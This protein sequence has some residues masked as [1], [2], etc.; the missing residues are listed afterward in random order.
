LALR[1]L[2]SHAPVVDQFP[3]FDDNLRQA[4]R[5]ETELFFDSILRED[6]SVLELLTADY[7]FVNDRLAE[8]YGIPGVQGS[9]FRRIEL[10]EEFDVRRGLL[11]K[12]S[13][14]T[15]SSQPGRTAPV[16][17]GSWILSTL[18]GIPP[19]DPP[20]DVPDLAAAA[21]DA[22]GNTR[23][24]TIREQY[25]QHRQNP[26]CQGCHKLMDPF[27]FAL[28][29]FDATGRLRLTDNGSPINSVDVMYDGT[30]VSGPS[31]VREFLVKYSDQFVRNLTENLLT[32]A[33]GRG[34]EYYDMPVVRSIVREAE[35]DDYRFESL[36]LEV[37]KSEPFRMSTVPGEDAAVV[38]QA[39]D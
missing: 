31:D 36:I 22:A 26:A 29:P 24:P 15:V 37:V 28:E 4:F 2:D 23:Q 20:A 13:M 38:A 9:R 1:N 7:T 25:E 21:E 39:Q 33:T 8:H 34:V 30:P 27:G 6:R 18:I 11:G 10:D 14:L 16:M 3:D 5:R 17:R 35:Q 32:Y 19:P 12:G